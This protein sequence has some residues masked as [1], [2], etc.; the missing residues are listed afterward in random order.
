MSRLTDRIERLEAQQP[1]QPHIIVWQFEDGSL[2]REIPEGA[3]VTIISWSDDE[4]ATP[5]HSAD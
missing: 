2:S 5:T 1:E 4:V 3:A